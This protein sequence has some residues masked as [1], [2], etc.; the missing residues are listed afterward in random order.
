MASTKDRTSLIGTNCIFFRLA[1]LLPNGFYETAVIRWV[2]R[3]RKREEAEAVIGM[4]G[5]LLEILSH[6]WLASSLIPSHIGQ[7]MLWLPFHVPADPELAGPLA[8]A[9]YLL[10]FKVVER[11]LDG[12]QWSSGD[13]NEFAPTSFWTQWV[14]LLPYISLAGVTSPVV[15]MA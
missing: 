3:A 9:L 6:G 1:R 5:L 2:L 8:M 10:A 12:L 15:T 4:V 14:A 11:F 13:Q 7:W